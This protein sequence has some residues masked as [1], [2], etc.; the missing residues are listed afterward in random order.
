MTGVGDQRVNGILAVL[1]ILLTWWLVQSGGSSVALCLLILVSLA[2]G[3]VLVMPIGG[4]DMPVV[5][6]LLNSYSGLAAAAT[7]FVINNDVLIIAGSLVGASGIILTQIMCKA[8][9][10]SLAHVLFGKLTAAAGCHRCRRNVRQRCGAP[11]RTTSRS[12]WIRPD[13]S[14]SSPAT[15]WRSPRPSTRCAIWPIN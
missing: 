13:G 7:G 11:A 9:N 15:A 8:M 14:Y 6:A 10:R 3:F 12:C 5:I 1:L 2:L 4:A